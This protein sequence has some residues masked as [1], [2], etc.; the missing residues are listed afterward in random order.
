MTTP[1]MIAPGDEGVSHAI[2]AVGDQLRLRAGS[3][4]FLFLLLSR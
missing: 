3:L 1:G 4:L 2:V